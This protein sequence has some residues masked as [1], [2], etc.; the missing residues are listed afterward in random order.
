MLPPAAQVSQWPGMKSEKNL[1]GAMK[2]K[3]RHSNAPAR[4]GGRWKIYAAAAGLA[5]MVAV[6]LAAF[7]GPVR[8]A[9]DPVVGEFTVD[10]SGGTYVFSEQRGKPLVYFFSFPG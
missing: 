4:K 8:E 10:T 2:R 9:A 3:N 5:A 6:A 7:S 1:E